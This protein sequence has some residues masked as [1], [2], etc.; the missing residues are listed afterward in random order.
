MQEVTEQLGGTAE[1]RT[2]RFLPRGLRIAQLLQHK[3]QTDRPRRPGAQLSCAMNS[4][5]TLITCLSLGLSFP[6][7]K[8]RKLGHIT[9]FQTSN[10]FFF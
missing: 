5:G 3:Q 8:I 7:C 1:A 2:N 9:G 6:T 10:F 4:L